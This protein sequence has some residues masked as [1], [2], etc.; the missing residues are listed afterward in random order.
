MNRAT[1]RSGKGDLVQ[2]LFAL[3]APL[4]PPP[5]SP[6]L[7]PP[8]PLAT[9]GLADRALLLGVRHGRLAVVRTLLEACGADIDAAVGGGPR[10]GAGEEA[11]AGERAG[12]A[13]R[14]DAR[15]WAN[16]GALLRA[17][18]LPAPAALSMCT[19][20]LHYMRVKR[21]QD[22]VYDWTGAVPL[23][24]QWPVT[25]PHAPMEEGEGEEPREGWEPGPRK[26]T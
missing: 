24:Q 6:T 7:E 8:P 4:A 16:G 26:V 5:R 14:A 9:L 20:A 15:E 23:L 18:R 13:A 2:Y 21:I 3:L 1:V 25:A 19:L 22:G 10:I 17:A 11:G 12:V